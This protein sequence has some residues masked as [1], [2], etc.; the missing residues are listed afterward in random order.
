H[1]AKTLQK[2]KAMGLQSWIA[3][4]RQSRQVQRNIASVG[5][6]FERLKKQDKATYPR[7]IALLFLPYRPGPEP[8]HPQMATEY[9]YTV[10]KLTAM[11]KNLRIRLAFVVVAAGAIAVLFV[12]PFPIA[13]PVWLGINLALR[14]AERRVESSHSAQLAH[15]E[16]IYRLGG[17]GPGI[18]RDY[19]PSSKLWLDNLRA[20]ERAGVPTV[21]VK[22]WFEKWP[23]VGGKK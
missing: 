6:V 8:A 13:W 16:S 21:D 19:Q 11:Q 22:A 7:S 3:D 10:A 12:V 17:F 23:G 18:D 9:R 20:F 4:W 15:L 5:K 1:A 2:L 14:Y